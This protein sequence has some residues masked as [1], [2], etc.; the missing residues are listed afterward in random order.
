MNP[1]APTPTNITPQ[2][3]PTPAAVVPQATPKKSKKKLIITILA[4]IIVVA[5]GIVAWQILTKPTAEKVFN[6][7]FQNNLSVNNYKLTMSSD[8]MGAIVKGDVSDVKNPKYESTFKME[9]AEGINQEFQF[10]GTYK[11]ILVKYP[12]SSFVSLEIPSQQTKE[13]ADKWTQVRKDGKP[14]ENTEMSFYE[15]GDPY[16]LF[17]GDII[18]GNFSDADRQ[19][20]MD[21]IKQKLLYS[22]NKDTVKKQQLHGR[23]VF[24]YEVTA[25]DENLLQFNNKVSEIVGQ[26]FD[27]VEDALHDSEDKS[28]IYVD[29]ETQRIVRVKGNE[30]GQKI[31]VDVV[32]DNVKVMAQPTEQVAWSKLY[33]FFSVMSAG[34]EAAL[35]EELD[36]N[37]GEMFEEDPSATDEMVTEEDALL[38]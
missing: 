14:L 35:Q 18:L 25:N 33:E 9:I 34:Q 4:A 19:K 7:M 22:Y 3:T 15:M 37:G 6:G 1:D 11:D 17:P 12:E 23:D 10:Y 24:V 28:T 26:K 20:L 29:I 2:S 13:F 32:Y 8:G 27:D 31:T 21:A 38:L 36:A 16:Q 5:G 30:D